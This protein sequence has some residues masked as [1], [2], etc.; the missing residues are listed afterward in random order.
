MSFL[1]SSWKASIFSGK[2]PALLLLQPGLYWFQVDQ[3]MPVKNKKSGRC[4]Q[5]EELAYPAREQIQLLAFW[6]EAHNWGETR[7]SS[8]K[9]GRKI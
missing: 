3:L 1:K 8:L 5:A 7:R 6:L 4:R 9:E 2:L